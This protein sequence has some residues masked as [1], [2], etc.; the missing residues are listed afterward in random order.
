MEKIPIA[1]I[2]EFRRKKSES[3]KMTLLKNLKKTKE[4]KDNSNGG[5]YWT[6][7][8]SSISQYFKDENQDIILDKIDDLLGRHDLT[9]SKTSKIMYQKNIEILHNFEDF[10]F[11][12]FKPK[13]K[14]KYISKPVEKSIIKIL[15]LPI[16]V[17]PQHVYTY[18]ENG[19]D[20]IGATWFVAKKDGFETAEIGIFTEALF[21]YL[22]INYSNKY[23]IDPIYC[24]AIDVTNLIDVRQ[25][26]IFKKEV[27]SLLNSSLEA[28]KKML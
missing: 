3:T 2:V 8:I 26:Q 7:S 10:N 18:E 12:S 1:K 27:P 4:K 25:N 5:D 11:E 23:E 19:I 16:Q 15:D 20:K 22:D 28:I 9:K 6:T 13:S 14:I 21:E 24:I 17:R